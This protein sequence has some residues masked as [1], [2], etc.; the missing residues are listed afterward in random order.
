MRGEGVIDF[1]E[2]FEKLETSN[3]KFT[4][5]NARDTRQFFF[6]KIEE[7]V[8]ASKPTYRTVEMLNDLV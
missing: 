5:D 8:R 6:R 2:R 3:W 7:N 4:Q 1:K